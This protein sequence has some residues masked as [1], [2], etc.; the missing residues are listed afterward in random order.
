MNTSSCDVNVDALE[1]TFL[2]E[3]ARLL[4]FLR[5]GGVVDDA[6]DLLQEAWLR[7]QTVEGPPPNEPLSYLFRLLHNLMLDRH[8]A[9][10]R[11][12]RRETAWVEMVGSAISGMS[13]DP[14]G[15]RR[16]IAAQELHAAHEALDALGE[17]TAGIFRRH[18]LEGL[19][20]RVIA[21]ELGMGLST[22][23]KHLRKAYRA[24]T[25]HRRARDEA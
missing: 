14:G 3:R 9:A 16:A 22:V 7:I 1:T 13:D 18:R 5:Q 25:D 12:R 21:V 2:G 6:E 11:K 20:Q 10:L 4:A 19:T 17:P 8:R 15:E 23:E 24:L